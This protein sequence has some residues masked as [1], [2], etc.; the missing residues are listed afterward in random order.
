MA[1]TLTHAGT[2]KRA[3]DLIPD[4]VDT[5]AT[6]RKW[7]KPLPASVA[8]V[9]VAEEFNAAIEVDLMFY[10]DHIILH[11]ICRCTRWHAAIEVKGRDTDTL[12][13]GLH[14]C[15]IRIHGPPKELLV[16]GEGGIAE[17]CKTAA[18]LD[19]N[20]GSSTAE[21]HC[22]GIRCTVSTHNLQRKIYETSL[23][24]TGSAK[25]S[26]QEIA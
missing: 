10:L 5:C 6:C 20:G 16:D 17:A 14:D 19:R 24:S 1:R 8:S 2:P 25:R 18:F 15:W 22:Y 23:S 21:R 9:N 7:I 4:I 26:L 12:I 13:E 11:C 3:I